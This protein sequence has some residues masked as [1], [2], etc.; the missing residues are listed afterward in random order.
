MFRTRNKNVIYTVDAT[1]VP[2]VFNQ[3]DAQRVDGVSLGV[4]GRI[5]RALATS[6]ANVAYL[7]TE[8]LSQNPVNAGKRLTLT[9]ALLGQRLDHLPTPIGLTVGGGVR[10]TDAVFINAANT[11][12]S[13]GYHIVD[14]MADLSR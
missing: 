11:I 14:A 1:A 5:T 13:P 9:P 2:P 7:D 8:N 6:L 3:D 10:V 12:K 4:A